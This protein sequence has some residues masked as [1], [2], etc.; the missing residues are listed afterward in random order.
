MTQ[1]PNINQESNA[2]NET[3]PKLSIDNPSDFRFHA[4]YLIYSQAWDKSSSPE[5]K[6]KLNEIITAL[7]RNEIDY[8]SFYEQI[9]QYRAEFNP[10][11]Y[12]GGGR[13]FIETQRKKDWRK[14]QERDARNARHRR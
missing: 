2:N 11:H 13:P 3:V 6:T 10:E 14:M 8:E 1:E 12:S 4:A 9:R 5:V 7:S